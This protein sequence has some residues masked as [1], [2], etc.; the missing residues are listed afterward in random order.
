MSFLQFAN[1]AH[2]KVPAY[3]GG[4][5]VVVCFMAALLSVALASAVVPRQVMPWTGLLLMYEWTFATF[6]IMFGSYLRVAYIWGKAT[7]GRAGTA[8][9]RSDSAEYNSGKGLQRCI[10]SLVIIIVIL[11]SL[12]WGCSLVVFFCQGNMWCLW[13]RTSAP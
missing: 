9:T 5:S 8:F 3:L 6:F 10:A 13:Y 11:L 7:G 1:G 4:V 2:P 12:F